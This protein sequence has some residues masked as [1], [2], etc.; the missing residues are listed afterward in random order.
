MPLEIRLQQV[1]TYLLSTV[2]LQ[3]YLVLLLITELLMLE[4]QLLMSK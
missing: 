3:F 1:Q 2:R 4:L